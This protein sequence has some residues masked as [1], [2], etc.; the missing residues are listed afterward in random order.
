MTRILVIDDEEQIRQLLRIMLEKDGY[1]VIDAADGEDGLQLFRRERPDLVITDLI[2]PKK[3][4]LSTIMELKQEFPAVKIIAVSGGG[5]I[6]PKRYLSLAQGLG[7][8]RVLYKPIMRDEL[9]TMV[10]QL[11]A[12]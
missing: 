10:R 6:E 2:M 1:G 9:I 11:L 8:L 3:D 4:G 5:A 12:Q 7:A